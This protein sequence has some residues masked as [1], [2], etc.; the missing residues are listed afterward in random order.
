MKQFLLPFLFFFSLPAFSQSFVTR[1]IRSFGAKG[2]G[3]TS[4]HEAFQRAAA[5]FNARGGN[6][7]LV[8]SKGVYLVG[9]QVFN[10]NTTT[11]PV[12]N[13]TDVLS[14][15]NVKNLTITG[16]PGSKIKFR[17][18]LF[19]GA[20]DPATGKAYKHNEGFFAKPP[21]LAIIG[22]A[23]ALNNCSD[24]TIQNLE[25]DGNN[26]E[27]VLGG[28]YGDTGYQI[29]HTGIFV[30]NS[31]KVT[32]NKV[33][34][35]HFGQDGIMIGNATGDS[36]VKDEVV[37]SNSVFEYNSRQGFSWIGGNDLNVINCKFNH[38]GRGKFSSA[39][40]AGVDIEAEVGS[41]KNGRFISC[42]FI[43]NAGAG[44]VADSGPSSDCTFTNCVFWGVT[45]WSVWVNKPGF[46]FIDSKI[47]GAFV[48][49]YDALKDV[50]ATVFT[51]C[52]FEDKPYNGKEPFGNFLI[53]TNYKRRVRFDNCTMIANKKKL[54]WME[55]NPAW[56]PEEKYQLNNCRLVFKGGGVPPEGNWVSLTRNIR[57]KN[58]VFEI[59]HP[60]AEKFYFNGI[61][62]NYNVDLGGNKYV[63]N[64]KE[65]KL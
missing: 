8:I 48:H 59:Q 1:D 29:P 11:L 60:T 44:L 25:L 24:V 15:E 18:G 36:K 46:R 55:S 31:R 37:L 62:E 14:L 20:F 53:E 17:K 6:G 4:D 3:K 7:E 52:H 64:N 9:K 57:Y 22:H 33:H 41:L 34:S 26:G 30:L 51:S 61:G 13:G 32:V 27:I 28:T 39:P 38:T 45:N 5:F 54:V 56:K 40:S 49:G 16:Q 21:Y 12:Y 35:H 65:R 19:Y 10:R 2:D 58:C 43:N 23:I 42:E 47:Y 50:E 63:V